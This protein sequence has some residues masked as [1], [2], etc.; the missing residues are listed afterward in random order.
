MSC[1]VSASEFDNALESLA[2]KKFSTRIA[3]IAAIQASHHPQAAA[4]LEAALNGNL[5]RLKRD[6]SLVISNGIG[7]AL[8]I[9]NATSTSS[10]V[11]P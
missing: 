10:K 8:T 2:G 9:T 5:Y 3:A 6:K 4:V 7:S 1:A 11:K